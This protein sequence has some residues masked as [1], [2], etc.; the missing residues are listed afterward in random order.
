MHGKEIRSHENLSAFSFPAY[1]RLMEAQGQLLLLLLP[2]SGPWASHIS[3]TP[4]LLLSKAVTF[5]GLDL[6]RANMITLALH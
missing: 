2:K 3:D 4:G 6:S 1:N 5:L